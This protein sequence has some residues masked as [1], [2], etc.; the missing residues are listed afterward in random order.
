MYIF[1]IIVHVI[2]C[3]ILIATILLQAGKGGGLTEMFGGDTAQS[4]LGT[5]APSILKKAT[6]IAA[7]GFLV[8]SLVLGMVTARRGRSLFEGAKF[9]DVPTAGKAGV[10]PIQAPAVDEKAA[11]DAGQAADDV[12]ESVPAAEDIQY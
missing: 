9:A 11:S 2:I 1:L 12:T 5:Q 6:E 4:V 8:T 7:V 3:L 10:T